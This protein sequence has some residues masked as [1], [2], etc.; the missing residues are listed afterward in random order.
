M[1][2]DRALDLSPRQSMLPGTR[3]LLRS[4]ADSDGEVCVFIGVGSSRC[5]AHQFDR[6]LLQDLASLGLDLRLDFYGTELPQRNLHP[7]A[8]R[9]A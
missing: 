6:Q 2:S 5:C 9:T 3:E 7:N 8:R 4:I 1:A